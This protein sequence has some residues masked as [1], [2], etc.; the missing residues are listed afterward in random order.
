M[1]IWFASRPRRNVTRSQNCFGI[2]LNQHG[3]TR[4]HDDD[5][6]FLMVPVPV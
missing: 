6:V 2:I 5:F 1:A 4:Q 3:L